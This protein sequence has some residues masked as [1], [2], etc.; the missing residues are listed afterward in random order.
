MPLSDTGLLNSEALSRFHLLQGA[1]IAS[2]RTILAPCTI[3][4]LGAGEI[5]ITPGSTD[6]PLYLLFSGRL[7][8]H[9]QSVND[10]PIHIFQEGDSIG[11]FSLIDGKPASAFV[12]ATEQSR[13]VSVDENSFWA[14]IRTSNGVARNLLMALTQYLRNSNNSLSESLRLQQEY[15]RQGVADELT[16]LYNRRWLKNTLQRQMDRA[17]INKEPLS[18]IMIDV[19]HFKKINDEFGHLA[20]DRVLQVVAKVIMN[21][22]RPTDL[23]ARYGGEEFIVV[24][25]DTAII[26]ARL[27][28]ERLREAVSREI[29]VTSNHT[30]LSPVTISLGVSQMQGNQDMAAFIA[31]ADAALYRAKDQGRNRVSN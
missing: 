25:P 30:P 7:S 2:I 20:G 22:V 11:E 6:H 15:Q 17:G 12:V 9:L 18:L 5:L 26:G 21:D 23:V 28:A 19:D 13:V 31:D 10:K 3:K 8:V 16:G 4:E 14:L 27:V 24:L 1:D 29:I